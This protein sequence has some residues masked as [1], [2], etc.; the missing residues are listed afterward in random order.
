VLD[1]E[2]QA[3]SGGQCFV[4]ERRQGPDAWHGQVQI[5]ELAESLDRGV[6]EAPLLANGAAARPPF[7]FFDLE[8]T[9]LS[10]GA[11]TYA[12]LVGCGWFDEARGFVTRQYVLARTVDERPMLQAVA[13]ELKRAGALVS[14]NGKSFDAPLLETRFL[15]HRLPWIGG[16]LPHVDVLH[17]ARRF[18]RSDA[19]AGEASCSLGTLERQVLGAGRRDDVAGFEAPARYFRFIRS[20]DARPL[21]GVVEHNRLDLLSLAALTIRLLR[22]VNEGPGEARDARE[23]LAVGR[24]YERAGLPARAAEAYG[25]ALGLDGEGTR[26]SRTL[27]VDALRGLAILAR[28]A[29]RHEEAAVRWRELLEQP[30]CPAGVAREAA[31]AL[32]IHHEHRVRDLELARD[33]ALRT[34]DGGGRA[35]RI[36]AVRHRLERLE[37]KLEATAMAAPLF[38]LED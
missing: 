7:V 6:S 4:V 17:P 20:G 26:L 36:H 38:Q 13:D 32:A 9:G 1:G 16:R 34:M 18:W 22:L 14:F 19:V 28:R 11:G 3:R 8:T 33:F 37:R 31:E 10:G 15:Y 27:R 25:H 12:F 21:S 23:A 5:G 2:W 35:A 24:L 30:G 29:R